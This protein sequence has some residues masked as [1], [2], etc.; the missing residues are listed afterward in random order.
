MKFN[1]EPHNR[2]LLSITE[3]MGYPEKTFGNP[4]YCADGPLTGLAVVKVLS[5]CRMEP[6][7]VDFASTHFHSCDTFRATAVG[8]RRRSLA[9]CR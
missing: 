9:C 4:D 6:D 1:D 7:E 3:A 5:G 8:Y 2:L